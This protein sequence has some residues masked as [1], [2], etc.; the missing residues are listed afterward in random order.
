MG[1]EIRDDIKTK[2]NRGIGFINKHMEILNQAIS[3]GDLHTADFLCGVIEKALFEIHQEI[4]KIITG[5]ASYA[6][7]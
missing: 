3:E 1:M 6:G 2:F 4:R 5:E 7:K